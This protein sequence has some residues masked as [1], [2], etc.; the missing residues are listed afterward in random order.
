MYGILYLNFIC[1]IYYTLNLCE[2]YQL[3]LENLFKNKS[4]GKWSGMP[5]LRGVRVGVIGKAPSQQSRPGGERVRRVAAWGGR[6]GDVPGRG[7]RGVADV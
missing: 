1:V 7:R 5:L 6:A 3:H 2:I 4:S